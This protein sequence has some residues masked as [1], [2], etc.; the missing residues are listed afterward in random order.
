MK[1]VDFPHS[2]VVF[3]ENQPQYLPLPAHVDAAGRVT[4]L[5][6]MTWYE[7]LYALVTGEVWVQQLSFRQPLQPQRVVVLR[8]E[9]NKRC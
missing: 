5:W 3:A 4:T 6:R 8:S 9:V 2:N 7:R 1:P